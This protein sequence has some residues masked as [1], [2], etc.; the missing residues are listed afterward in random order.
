V[1][2]R[3]LIRKP[4]GVTAI[5]VFLLVA[6]WVVFLVALSLVIYEVASLFLANALFGVIV[7]DWSWW[8]LRAL[9]V[10]L[11]FLGYRGL[12]VGQM[13]LMTPATNRRA[14]ELAMW[15]CIPISWVL[16]GALVTVIEEGELDLFLVAFSGGAAVFWSAVFAAGAFYMRSSRVRRYFESQPTQHPRYRALP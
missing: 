16:M 2:T 6:G 3:D 11:G 13:L 9:V 5:G 7:D 8:L 14:G 10:L 1:T 12:R 15:V 4:A